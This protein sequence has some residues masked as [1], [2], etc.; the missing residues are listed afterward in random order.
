[1]KMNGIPTPINPYDD[2]PTVRL[3]DRPV[4]GIP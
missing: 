1:V 4:S 3:L 2:A